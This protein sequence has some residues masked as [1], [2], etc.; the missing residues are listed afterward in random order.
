MFMGSRVDV[1]ACAF[2]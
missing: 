2:T 1:F